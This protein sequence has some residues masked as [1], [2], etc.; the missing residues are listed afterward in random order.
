MCVLWCRP[1]AQSQHSRHCSSAPP[2]SS[3]TRL[4]HVGTCVPHCCLLSKA[5]VPASRLGMPSMMRNIYKLLHWQH[6]SVGSWAPFGFLSKVFV[7]VLCHLRCADA[8][9]KLLPCHHLWCLGL[10]VAYS[11]S[12]GKHD[13]P[14][15][16]LCCRGGDINRKVWAE[17]RH[18]GHLKEHPTEYVTIIQQFFKSKLGFTAPSVAVDK[19][20]SSAQ[21]AP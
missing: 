14:E 6:L 12:V 18:V 16:C 5:M 8:V 1:L 7:V 2:S 10:M 4:G 11:C 21:K 17:S 19:A 9:L 20:T 13:N 3:A 15:N